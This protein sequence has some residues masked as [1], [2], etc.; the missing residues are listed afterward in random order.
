MPEVTVN[1]GLKN[2]FPAEMYAWAR[3]DYYKGSHEAFKDAIKSQ[4]R[5]FIFIEDYFAPV[6]T[7]VAGAGLQGMG[8]SG[9]TRALAGNVVWS[10]GASNS[11]MIA[12]ADVNAAIRAL[13]M[14]NQAAGKFF[15]WGS[16][17]NTKTVADFTLQSLKDAG[18]TKGALEGLVKAYYQVAQYSSQTRVLIYVISN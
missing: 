18:I 3:R 11:A 10:T 16:S 17:V 7:T 14:S 13:N 9:V 2:G 5:S 12:A 6:V 8:V 4:E 15:G 1:L